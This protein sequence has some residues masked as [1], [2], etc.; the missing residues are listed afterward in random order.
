M[1]CS[2]HVFSR[3]RQGKKKRGGGVYMKKKG[4]GVVSE[5]AAG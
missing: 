5:K 1:V 3:P 2:W 4:V